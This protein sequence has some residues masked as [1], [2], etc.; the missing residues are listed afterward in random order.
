MNRIKAS[1]AK[2]NAGLQTEAAI[3]SPEKTASRAVIEDDEEDPPEPIAG[4][5]ER[6]R[7]KVHE[8]CQ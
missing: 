6:K 8:H 3:A 1:I 2:R 4:T 7:G 5:S